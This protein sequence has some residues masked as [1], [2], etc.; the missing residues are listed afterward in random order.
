LESKGELDLDAIVVRFGALVPKPAQKR[1]SGLEQKLQAATATQAIASRARATV[2]A[3][4]NEGAV[5]L[6]PDRL[7]SADKPADAPI[8]S[9]DTRSAFE[10]VF[11]A[12]MVPAVEE[13]VDA[14]AT[15]VTQVARE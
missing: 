4:T 9:F 3:A 5:T 7:I 8:S 14:A 10:R 15:H 2:A 1:M 13:R 11:L 6:A 12:R